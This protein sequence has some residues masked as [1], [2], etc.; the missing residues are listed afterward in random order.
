M[1]RDDGLYRAEEDY[2]TERA[3]GQS[4]DNSLVACHGDLLKLALS[5]SKTEAEVC[6]TLLFSGGKISYVVSHSLPV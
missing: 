5:W 1:R 4:V 2:S 6:N 3:E